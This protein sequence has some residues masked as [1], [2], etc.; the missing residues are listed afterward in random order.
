VRHSIKTFNTDIKEPL[1]RY[2]R[3]DALAQT[4]I[5]EFQTLCVEF[6][7]AVVQ[8]R[9]SS[10]SSHAIG[11]VSQRRGPLRDQFTGEVFA[12]FLLSD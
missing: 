9:V 1:H 3:V 4:H 6:Y 7:H 10:G 11:G 5:R 2:E 8:R 12:E